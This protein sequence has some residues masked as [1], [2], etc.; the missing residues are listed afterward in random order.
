MP[1]NEPELLGLILNEV[2]FVAFHYFPR[3]Y[4]TGRIVAALQR[5][6]RNGWQFGLINGAR[7]K[8]QVGR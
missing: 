1:R 2:I 8:S 7:V 3:S 6:F 5:R 4:L